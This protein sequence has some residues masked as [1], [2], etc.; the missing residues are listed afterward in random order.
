MKVGRFLM[1][2]LFLMLAW[3][4]IALAGWTTVFAFSSQ[5]TAGWGIAAQWQGAVTL[6][7]AVVTAGVGAA[8]ASGALLA[9]LFAV[10]G[11]IARFKSGSNK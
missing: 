10:Q 5:L 1:F 4:V 11:F 6:A 2:V 3:V 7:L 8:A 9:L